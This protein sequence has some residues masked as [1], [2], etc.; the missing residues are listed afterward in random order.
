MLFLGEPNQT[1][2]GLPISTKINQVGLKRGSVTKQG[3]ISPK[4]KGTGH[5][6]SGGK[7][8]N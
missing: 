2:K 3:T 6:E 8:M 1:A 4:N 7:I 5:E